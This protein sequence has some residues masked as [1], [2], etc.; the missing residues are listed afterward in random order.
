MAEKTEIVLEGSPFEIAAQKTALQAVAKMP[1]DQRDA[2][3]AF[4]KL[5]AGDRD[6]IA[7]IIRNP[8]AVKAIRDNWL[9]LK[10]KFA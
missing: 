2:I 9:M 3:A 5:E 7:Q 4:A 1:K 8:K 10:L 6:R